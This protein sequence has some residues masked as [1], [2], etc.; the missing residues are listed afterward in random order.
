[1]LLALCPGVA[2]GA[3]AVGTASGTAGYNY[4]AV[5][6]TSGEFSATASDVT[7]LSNWNLTT[8]GG[9]SITSITKQSATSVRLDLNNPMEAGN[10]LTLQA[11][12]NVFAAG[13]EPFAAPIAVTIT[14]PIVAQGTATATAGT[15]DITV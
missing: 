5:S 13:T 10:T 11:N 15:K 8:T 1:M 14:V 9:Q 12:A 2:Y 4:I 7:E 3:A 6:L